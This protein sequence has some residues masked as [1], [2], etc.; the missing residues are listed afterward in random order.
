MIGI[1]FAKITYSAVLVAIYNA[2]YAK[3]FTK[4]V[5]AI[6]K[7][8]DFSLLINSSFYSLLI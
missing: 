8:L 1:A 5:V 6:N 7:L 3:D 4:F 2:K